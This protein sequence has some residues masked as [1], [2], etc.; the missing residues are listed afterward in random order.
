VTS[1]DPAPWLLLVAAA[2]LGFQL[3]VDL[4]VYP[5]L[6]EAPEDRWD[7]V[8]ARHSRRIAPLV[9]VLYVPLVLLLGWTLAVAPRT[10]G[11]WLA[12]AGGAIAVVTT[13]ALAAP[14]HGRLSAVPVAERP[15]L[16]RALGRA[17]RIRTVGAAVCV[18]GAVLVAV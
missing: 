2:H 5:A 3:T 4:V 10:E 9:A 7:E 13:A 11:A 1:T 12:A 8:H 6:G 14:M 18:V 17:D 16:L 15:D